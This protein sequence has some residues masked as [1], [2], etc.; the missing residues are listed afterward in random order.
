MLGYL[1]L[2]FTLIPVIEL[3]L[4]IRVGQYIGAGYTVAIVIFTGVAGAYL[5]KMQG[6]LTL[7]RI[8]QDVNQG[9]MPADKLFDGVL[10]LCSGI[11]LLTPGFLTDIIGFI[12]LLPLT[13][14]WFK[15]WL[16]RK[17]ED[18]ISQG[19]VITISSF[20]NRDSGHF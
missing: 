13:R 6:L 8:E 9:I 7:R 20:K 17:I 4:L 3:M 1:I 16:R 2:L 12:G 10:I 5:A 15:Q 19:K 11:L 14:N 18:I